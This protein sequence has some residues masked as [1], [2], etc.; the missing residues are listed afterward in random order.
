[1][2]K[3]KLKHFKNCSFAIACKSSIVFEYLF[4]G[5]PIIVPKNGFD[6]IFDFKLN[7]NIFLFNK[8]YNN[9]PYRKTYFKKI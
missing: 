3:F 9:L 6:I 4:R 8:T 7:K 5:I 1:M 2:D